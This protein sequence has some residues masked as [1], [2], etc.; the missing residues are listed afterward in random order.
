M[1][2]AGIYES[3]KRW[4]RVHL[5]ACMDVSDSM[6]ATL[7]RLQN[8]TV[9]V[10]TTRQYWTDSARALGMVAT[11]DG[12]R[13]DRNPSIPPP[14]NWMPETNKP[15][16]SADDKSSSDAQQSGGFICFPQDKEVIPPY[17]YFLMRQVEPC[18]FTEA[19]RFVAR[20]KG[21]VGFAGFQ[22]R[23]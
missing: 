1:H 13:F 17:V 5:P 23:H 19:D 2:M 9:W 12:I 6:Q 7:D 15:G 14:V 11:S 21:P 20:S 16:G 3:V 4:Q 18:Y 10:P 8:D 22:C